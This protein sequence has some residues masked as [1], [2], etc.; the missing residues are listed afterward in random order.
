MRMVLAVVLGLIVA[1]LI[2]LGVGVAYDAIREAEDVPRIGQNTRHIARLEDANRVLI[3]ANHRLVVA[4]REALCKIK[5]ATVLLTREAVR[6]HQASG[7]RAGLR[8]VLSIPSSSKC[9]PGAAAAPKNRRSLRIFPSGE[10]FEQF[11]NGQ[12]VPQT[13]ISRPRQHRKPGRARRP[14]PR[15]PRSTPTP[16]PAPSPIPAPS[17]PSPPAPEPPASTEPPERRHGH[18]C[19]VIVCVETNLRHR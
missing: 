12:T 8:V 16:P 5:L 7:L 15:Q 2:T 1:A 18:V 4:D 11:L 10:P 13:P 6:A 17:A 9:L 14:I 3:A 19:V